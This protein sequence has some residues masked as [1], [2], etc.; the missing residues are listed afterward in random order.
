MFHSILLLVN[1]NVPG[2]SKQDAMEIRTVCSRSNSWRET[3]LPGT[4]GL[5]RRLPHHIEG[6]VGRHSPLSLLPETMSVGGVGVFPPFLLPYLFPSGPLPTADGYLSVEDPK[7]TGV[8]SLSHLWMKTLSFF[9]CLY[10]SVLECFSRYKA[11]DWER[12]V[13]NPRIHFIMTSQLGV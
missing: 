2:S 12:K 9:C 11:R 10:V 7:L 13:N 4:S 8:C 1:Q 6:S 5:Q 3:D